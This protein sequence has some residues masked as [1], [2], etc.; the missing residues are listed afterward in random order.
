MSVEKY[1]ARAR[2]A[3]S[4]LCVGLDPQASAIPERYRNEDM[5]QFAW[6][7]AVIDATH[8]FVAAYK[9][10][11]AFYEER[12]VQGLRELQ[13][14]I[15]YL[16]EHHPDIFTICDAKRAD[17]GH[18]NEAY[19]AAIF[20]LMGFDAVT[21]HPYLGREALAPFIG[22]R[23]KVSLILCRTSNPGAGDVQDLMVDGR[24]LW[25]VVAEKV[26]R[27][28][29]AHNNLMLVVGATYP[30][31]MRRIR[32]VAGDITFLVP[33][34]GAQGGDVQAAVEAGLNSV[35]LGL[36]IS[37]SRSIISAGNPAEA[38]STLRDEVNKYRQR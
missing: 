11:I 10:N 15:A 34:V 8:A 4:L 17:I 12:G 14:T 13:L 32:E 31:E 25:Q 36:I 30:G 5:P 1:E 28:W 6:N 18:T 26:S 3:N 9:P 21:L 37:A 22:R 33:G 2:A 35:G 38:A 27:E 23:D 19:A 7:R 24:P 20:D 16:R 29:S